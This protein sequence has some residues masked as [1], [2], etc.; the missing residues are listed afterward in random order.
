MNTTKTF[1]RKSSQIVIA[2]AVSLQLT[3]CDSSTDLTV[4]PNANFDLDNRYNKDELDANLSRPADLPKFLVSG[5]RIIIDALELED[6]VDTIV[7]STGQVFLGDFR[8]NYNSRF[9]SEDNEG[10]L[11]RSDDHAVIDADDSGNL[12]SSLLT[13]RDSGNGSGSL[14]EALTIDASKLSTELNLTYFTQEQRGTIRDAIRSL[15]YIVKDDLDV[16]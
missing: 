2:V 11:V 3:Q 12:L 15:G 1:L 4:N 13:L 10:S 5:D 9:G 8:F 6:D 14:A 16:L 7:R